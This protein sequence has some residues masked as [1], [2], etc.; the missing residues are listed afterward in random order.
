MNNF[1]IIISLLAAFLALAF[2]MYSFLMRDRSLSNALLLLA[3]SVTASLEILDLLAMINPE[4]LLYWKKYAFLAEASLPFVWLLFTLLFAR[5]GIKEISL[6]QRIFLVASLALIAVPCVVPVNDLIYSPDFSNEPVLFLSRYGFA[7]YLALITGLTLALV[8]LEATF[9]SSSGIRRWNIKYEIFGASSLL[10]GFFIYYAHSFLYRTISM[11]ILLARSLILLIAVMLIGYS[12]SRSSLDVRIHVSRKMAYN[13]MVLLIIGIYL[14]GLALLGEGVKYI[15]K[16]FD[17][18]LALTV[19]IVS[20]IALVALIFSESLKRKLQVFLGAHFYQNKYDYRAQWLQFTDALSSARSGEELSSAIVAVFC[21]TFG[22]SSGALFLKNESLSGYHLAVNRDMTVPVPFI[23]QDD[24]FV[25]SL[26]IGS[27]TPDIQTKNV[28]PGSPLDHLLT[29]NCVSFSIPI[30]S[31]DMLTGFILAGRPLYKLE[32]YTFEDYDLMNTIA[33]QAAAALLN[34]KLTEQLTQSREMEA[35][36]KISAF[37]IHDLKNLAQTLSLMVSNAKEYISDPSFQKDL[38]S[39]LDNSATRMNTLIGKLASMPD[40]GAL[41]LGAEDL[42]KLA[43]Q[44]ANAM[45]GSQIR[46][47]GCPVMVKIDRERLQSVIINLA[48][49]AIDATDGIGSIIIETGAEN[50]SAFIRVKDKGCGIPEEFLRQHLFSPFK[51]TKKS[52]MGIGLYQCRQITEAHNGRIEAVSSVG[53]GSTF[54]VWL[55]LLKQDGQ[56][57]LPDNTSE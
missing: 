1:Q 10:A 16:S 8:N 17:K 9:A 27:K 50:G 33:H 23:S 34:L 32:N 41:T 28:T 7:F 20:G 24:P 48:L 19:A 36:G 25:R 22:M 45:S 29:E 11:N 21:D 39:S 18:S 49:N 52:G 4:Q 13:S 43:T 46:V 35:L 42:L 55:P 12:Q 3:L 51:T 47:Q 2:P 15:D 31:S 14:I 30:R 54:T 56:I 40:K 53:K 38:L 37:M 57:D 44:V 26:E 5:T 6:L